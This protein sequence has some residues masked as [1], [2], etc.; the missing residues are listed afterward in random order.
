M[1]GCSK[2]QQV[3]RCKFCGCPVF[4]QHV[5]VKNGISY[6]NGTWVHETF[7][8]GG[9]ISCQENAAKKVLPPDESETVATV[10]EI[11]IDA[12]LNDTIKFGISAFVEHKPGYYYPEIAHPIYQMLPADYNNLPT[13]ERIKA[14]DRDY[15]K[16]VDKMNPGETR[17]SILGQVK[18]TY[19]VV[20]Q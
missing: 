2:G 12:I 10:D 9:Y 19:K 8:D 6:Q 17:F 13:E 7:E 15:K 3:I 16:Y 18:R 1:F 11:V 14:I 20:N 5:E 4:K